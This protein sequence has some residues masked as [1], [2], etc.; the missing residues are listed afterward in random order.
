MKNCWVTVGI[1]ILFISFNVYCKDDCDNGNDLYC[2]IFNSAFD[3]KIDPQDGDQQLQDIAIRAYP[4][5]FHARM[6]YQSILSARSSTGNCD[7]PGVPQFTSMCHVLRSYFSSE[8]CAFEKTNSN[9]SL[10]TS[11]RLAFDIL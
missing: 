6:F 11:F 5:N 3:H 9:S 10:R 1:F 4:N 2:Q 8:N 7:W